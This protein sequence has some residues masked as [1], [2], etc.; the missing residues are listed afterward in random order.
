[1]MHC[2]ELAAD[3]ITP[4]EYGAISKVFSGELMERFGEAALDI[5]GHARRAFRSRCRARS[6]TAGS[7][8]TC[9]IP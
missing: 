1:M 9:V 7:S 4:P 2:A 6:T 5:L 3:G 8:R